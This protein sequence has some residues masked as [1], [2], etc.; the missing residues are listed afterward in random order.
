MSACLQ[1]QLSHLSRL[2]PIFLSCLVQAESSTAL[3]S[4]ALPS[5]CNLHQCQRLYNTPPKRE[6]KIQEERFQMKENTEKV[7]KRQSLRAQI[8]KL[9]VLKS[10]I[11]H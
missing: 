6:F 1:P 8:F 2:L 5:V 10:E 3:P 11:S 9:R 4:T 7:L